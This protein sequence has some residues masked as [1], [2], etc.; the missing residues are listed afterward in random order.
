[1]AEDIGVEPCFDMEDPKPRKEALK[2]M[3]KVERSAPAKIEAEIPMET[4]EKPAEDGDKP[5][6]KTQKR[7]LKKAAAIERKER[8]IIDFFREKIEKIA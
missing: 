5:M 2:K 7:K 1:M 6:S 3:K 4:D 8:V